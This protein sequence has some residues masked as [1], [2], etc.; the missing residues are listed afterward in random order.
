MQGHESSTDGTRSELL[1]KLHRRRCVVDAR[2]DHFASSPKENATADARWEPG[3]FLGG[4]KADPPCSRRCAVPFRRCAVP[5]RELNGAEVETHQRR[6]AAKTAEAEGCEARCRGVARAQPPTAAPGSVAGVGPAAALET[7]RAEHPE[8]HRTDAATWE[9]PCGTADP[10]DGAL[11][12]PQGSAAEQPVN[13]LPDSEEQPTDQSSNSSEQLVGPQAMSEKQLAEPPGG[14]LKQLLESLPD[15]EEPAEPSG[16]DSQQLAE[17]SATTT[18][19]RPETL[20]PHSSEQRAELLD[21]SEPLGSASE[22]TAEPPASASE[23]AARPHARFGRDTSAASIRDHA[24]IHGDQVICD[25]GHQLGLGFGDIW[26]RSPGEAATGD[27]L[28][29]VDSCALSETEAADQHDAEVTASISDQRRA[30][31]ESGMGQMVPEPSSSRP[32][33]AEAEGD[34]HPRQA[35]EAVSLSPETQKGIGCDAVAQAEPSAAGAGGRGTTAAAESSAAD[36]RGRRAVSVAEEPAVLAEGQH[37]G[38]SALQAPTGFATA[39]DLMSKPRAVFNCVL[40]DA[41]SSCGRDACLVAE[42]GLTPDADVQA[43]HST[44]G[45]PCARQPVLEHTRDGYTST[46][47]TADCTEEVVSVAEPP[48]LTVDSRQTPPASPTLR[49]TLRLSP[50][51]VAAVDR[52]FWGTPPCTPGNIAGDLAR[53]EFGESR[54]APA[55]PPRVTCVDLLELPLLDPGCGSC[56]DASF[57]E[58]SCDGL[59]DSAQVARLQRELA[60]MER[61]SAARLRRDII[62]AWRRLTTVSAPPSPADLCGSGTCCDDAAQASGAPLGAAQQVGTA[63]QEAA[64]HEGKVGRVIKTSHAREIRAA[65]EALNQAVGDV[66]DSFQAMRAEAEAQAQAGAVARQKAVAEARERL[67]GMVLARTHAAENRTWEKSAAQASVELQP[68]DGRELEIGTC[69]GVEAPW[70]PRCT[71]PAFSDE[72]S[73]RGRGNVNLVKTTI[74]GEP[75]QGVSGDAGPIFY[76]SDQSK[77]FGVSRRAPVP[78]S[79]KRGVIPQA[80]KYAGP[81]APEEGSASQATF[82]LAA[83]VQGACLRN[84][85]SGLALEQRC[86]STTTIVAAP[87]VEPR[88]GHLS[89]L[90]LEGDRAPH[91]RCFT[92]SCST[93]VASAGSSF[94]SCCLP[95]RRVQV[96]LEA[97]PAP[98]TTAQVKADVLLEKL[99]AVCGSSRGK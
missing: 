10:V 31:L 90:S 79:S 14:P 82:T 62:E 48:P 49:Y 6:P 93:A 60:T 95:S 47:R 69:D 98:A 36:S 66:R 56:R 3:R 91:A 59:D 94:S 12:G 30:R 55:R 81:A 67:R 80:Q 35:T 5:F 70:T 87:A 2:G 43:Y 25:A 28:S 52:E 33:R 73:P 39:S 54:A 46:V 83:G 27:A 7:P 72:T 92:H 18:W 38:P 88:P 97:V 15:S 21:P 86:G 45:F 8:Q 51:T 13:P 64:Q 34:E 75:P 24:V 29:H 9:L 85:T 89:A 22:Q 26:N 4:P 17:T 84:T 11:P 71:W 53:R 57:R 19:K 61:A 40:A 77:L 50:A 23:Q 32:R 63:Q 68:R 74:N 37:C 76:V 42:R 78:K 16:N 1:L 65:A 99:V 44:S 58:D 96:P 41:D 20:G